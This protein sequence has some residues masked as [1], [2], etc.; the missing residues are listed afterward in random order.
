MLAGLAQIRKE[1]KTGASLLRLRALLRVRTLPCSS[2]CSIWLQLVREMVG[3]GHKAA[4]SSLP[5]TTRPLP[6]PIDLVVCEV[7]CGGRV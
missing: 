2:R 6:L 4:V 3:A 5:N 7:V 1:K